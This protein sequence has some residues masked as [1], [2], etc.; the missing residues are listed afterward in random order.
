MEEIWIYT[1]R[2]CFYYR[3]HDVY[4]IK[5]AVTKTKANLSSQKQWINY[6]YP[7]TPRIIDILKGFVAQKPVHNW[8]SYGLN[9]LGLHNTLEND[10]SPLFNHVSR[11]HWKWSLLSHQNTADSA[12]LWIGVILPHH[13][14]ATGFMN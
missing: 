3:Y 6:H 14:D 13:V 1:M 2:W 7:S 10:I 11:G 4:I 5:L 12:A 8:L 9:L